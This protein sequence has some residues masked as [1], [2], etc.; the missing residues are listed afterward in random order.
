MI[1]EDKDTILWYIME[2]A[3]E[4]SSYTPGMNK[5]LCGR[6]CKPYGVWTVPDN[7][8]IA[9]HS[10]TCY[11]FAFVCAIVVMAMVYGAY[12]ECVACP[13]CILS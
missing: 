5:R 10:L 12:I 8:E 11:F 7:K 3:S 13:C 2:R 9:W 4:G 6:I 1:D